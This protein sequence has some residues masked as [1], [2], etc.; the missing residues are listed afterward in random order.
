MLVDNGLTTVELQ[1]AL[2]FIFRNKK[3]KGFVIAADEMDRVEFSQYPI[4]IIQN[5]QGRRLFGEHWICYWIPRENVVEYFDSFANPISMYNVQ[6]P[7]GE[8]LISNH[9]VLQS[10]KNCF[11]GHFCLYFLYLRSKCNS[12][13]CAMCKFVSS[14]RINDKRVSQ[15]YLYIKQMYKLCKHLCMCFKSSCVQLCKPK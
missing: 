11:C 13:N 12:F 4:C 7:P 8:I 6:P 5:N 10:D 15:F 1:N 14:K 9:R 2:D 3:I